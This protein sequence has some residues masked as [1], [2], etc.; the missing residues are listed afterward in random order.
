MESTVPLTTQEVEIEDDIEKAVI[1]CAIKFIPEHEDLFIK[2]RTRER[3]VHGE[4][5]WDKAWGRM[6]KN[7]DTIDPTSF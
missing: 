2:K 7:P 5:I 1:E 6:L 3:M 4:N